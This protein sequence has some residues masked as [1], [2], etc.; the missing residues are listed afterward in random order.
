VDAGGTAVVWRSWDERDGWM[1]AEWLSDPQECEWAIGHH[2][3]THEDFVQWQTSGDQ[4]GYVLEYLG[5]P[6]A[7]GEVWVDHAAQ[8]TE[9]AHIIVAPAARGQG[10]GKRITELLFLEAVKY[11]FPWTYMR[12]HPVNARAVACYKSVR[13]VEWAEADGDWSN[14]WTWLRRMK[15]GLMQCRII[16][17]GDSLVLVP[18]E[19]A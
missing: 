9:L 12:V 18:P 2:P 11:G 13:F 15:P 14:D 7:Y 1:L 8:D 17:E 4:F 5:D 6:V 10:W 19:S 3:F 16:E